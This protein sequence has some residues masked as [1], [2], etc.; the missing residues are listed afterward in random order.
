MVPE[1]KTPKYEI[2]GFVIHIISYLFFAIY[3]CW[4][5]IPDTILHSIGI[6]YYPIRYWALAIPAWLVMFVAFIYLMFF[7]HNLVNTPPLNSYATLTDEHALYLTEISDRYLDPDS[8]PEIRDI[9]ISEVNR[10]VYQ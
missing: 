8:I 4:A 1:T 5:Y 7:A 10:Y 3:L 6:S 2:Y 9:P